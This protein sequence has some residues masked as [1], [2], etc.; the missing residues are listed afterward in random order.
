MT[1]LLDRGRFNDRVLR[2]LGWS[3]AFIAGAINAGG[4]LAVH[5]Y[6]SH[7][8]GVVSGMADAWAMGEVRLALSLLVML[9]C[10]IGGAMHSTWLILWARRQRLRGGYGVSMMEEAALLLLF[11][12][13]GAGL[14]LHKGLFT[15]PTVMLLCFI[16]GMHNT[17]VTKLSGG[18]L[19][20]T[21]MTGIATDIGIEL[22]KMSYYNRQQGPRVQAVRANRSKFRVYSLILLSFFAGGVVGALGFKHLGF[23]FTLP[24][25]LLLFL[26]G[27]RPAWYD[28]KLRWRWW[29]IRLAAAKAQ[30]GALRRT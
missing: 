25:A 14:S 5:R 30:S 28:V 26:L 10:F 15:P 1:R 6:T 23:G 2:Q 11:G 12:L 29:R 20:S 17:I 21:H 22:A 7:V 9:C 24:L 18:L 27:L 16:M 13:L 3:M 4:F 8:S 19:R